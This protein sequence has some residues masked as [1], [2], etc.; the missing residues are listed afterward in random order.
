M[1]KVKPD[2]KKKKGGVV[3][4]FEINICASSTALIPGKTIL[5]SVEYDRISSDSKWNV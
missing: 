2:L 5:K 4:C 1:G 3:K